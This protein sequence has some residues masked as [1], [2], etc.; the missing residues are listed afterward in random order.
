MRVT[1]KQNLT[2]PNGACF[3]ARQRPDG[4]FEG[5]RYVGYC[6]SFAINISTERLEKYASN[7]GAREK[8]RDI[9]IRTDRTC[10]FSLSDISPENLQM[11]FAGDIETEA[12]AATPKTDTIGE[13]QGGRHYYLGA[14]GANPIGVGEV[15][16]VTVEVGGV[17]LDEDVD[18]EVDKKSGRIYVIAGGGADGEEIEITYTPVAKTQRNVTSGT[19]AVKGRFRIEACNLDGENQ[20]TVI[21]L[22]EVSP[23]G[24][25]SPITDG[26][27]IQLDFEGRIVKL[28]SVPAVVIS[29][30]EVA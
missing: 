25:F 23:S 3:F 18:F 22:M 5:E 1:D 15:S 26:E 24:D 28:P 7:C 17:E 14:S 2:A 6:E 21:P 11:F 16:A 29:G 10:S 4:T 13:A 12:I 8:V 30:V 19:N 20:D 27:Y 9:V